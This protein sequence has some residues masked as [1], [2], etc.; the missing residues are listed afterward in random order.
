ML[1]FVIGLVLLGLPGS[2]LVVRLWILRRKDRSESN[3]TDIPRQAAVTLASTYALWWLDLLLF[4]HYPGLGWPA[5]F[6]LAWPLFAMLLAVLGLLL[7]SFA[8]NDEKLTL[9]IANVLFFML[10]FSSIIAPN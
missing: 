7:S 3:W 6:A 1:R 2:A 9:R 10:A 8:R 4:A 5:G